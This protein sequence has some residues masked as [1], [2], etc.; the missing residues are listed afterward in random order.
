M[1]GFVRLGALFHASRDHR[2]TT[3]EEREYSL[4]LQCSITGGTI[5]ECTGFVFKGCKL[6]LIRNDIGVDKDTRCTNFFDVVE[7]SILVV[8]TLGSTPSDQ[9]YSVAGFVTDAAWASNITAMK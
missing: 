7:F 2:G 6:E 3:S 9:S 4:L 8:K 1:T 5:I